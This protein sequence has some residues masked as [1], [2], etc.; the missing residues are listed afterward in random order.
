MKYSNILTSQHDWVKQNLITITTKKGCYDEVTCSY[1]GMKGKRYGIGSEI[2][3][4]PNKYK[5]EHVHLCPKAPKKEFKGKI[6]ITYCT[7]HGRVFANLTP[8]SIHEIVTPPVGYKNGHTGV[9]VMG[10]GEPVKVL[11]NE[12]IKID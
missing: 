10:V 2:I 11:S 3:E 6:Q 1:C 5:S 12:F 7:A 4:V 8:N 9:W